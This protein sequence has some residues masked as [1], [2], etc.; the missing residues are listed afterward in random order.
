M[1]Y[2]IEHITKLYKEKDGKEKYALKDVSFC[3]PNNGLVVIK[4]KSG[5]GKSTLL[6]MLSLIDNPTKGDIYFNNENITKY[7]KRKRNDYRKRHISIIFQHYHLLDNETSLFNVMLPSLINGCS[8]KDAKNKALILLKDI[9]F[10]EKLYN[11][12]VKYLSG[13]EKERIAI[14]RSLINNPEVILADEPTGALDSQN[15][16]IT[17]DLLKK[18]SKKKLVIV[19]T[20]ND[21]LAS[22]YADRIITLKDGTIK[23]DKMVHKI[24]EIDLKINNAKRKHNDYYINH[25]TKS[26]FKK[27]FKRNLIS[28]I[29]LVIGLSSSLLIIGFSSG[30]TPSLKQEITKQFDYGVGSI[31]KEISHKIEGSPL[32]MVEMTRPSKE[33][34]E[35][36]E[37]N[38][39]DF[40][41]TYDYSSLVPMS[42]ETKHDEEEIEEIFYYPIYSY[43]DNY[44]DSSLLIDGYIPTTDSLKEVVIN[45]TCY[46]LLN[47]KYKFSPLNTYLHLYYSKEVNYFTGD[48]ERPY[49]SDYFVYEKEVKI[50]GVVDEMNF[51]SSPKIYYPY[52]SLI[53][54]L[55][56]TIMNNLSSYKEDFI[57]WYDYIASISNNDQLSSYQIK[58]FI[59][60]YHNY[61]KIEEISNNLSSPFSYSSNA[62]TIGGALLDLVKAATIGMDAFLVIAL[63]GT[64]LIL[65]IVSFSSYSED[66]KISAILS[67]LG[68]SEDDITSI[69]IYENVF[70]GL[71][72]LVI[73]LLISILLTPLVNKVIYL[74]S[75][76]SSLIN[77]P[78]DS[79]LSH[80][81]FLPILLTIS[82]F[83]VSILSTY[84]PI[85]FSKKV[86]IK[87]E[88]MS[89]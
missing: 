19:I 23:E 1:L 62:L 9:G 3:L 28:I 24:K 87:E 37:N 64:I 14:L 60:D 73:S 43:L 65:G 5:S 52:V 77:I 27:R 8:Y 81:F 82:T 29:S 18:E 47:K 21:E 17:M 56:N 46:N 71:I 40:T 86:S 2:R 7:R 20:H 10:S 48:N 34:I 85:S 59:N 45:K 38:Y 32:S 41:F 30:A 66:K 36:I 12:K 15:S 39:P 22:L 79:F 35:H 53:D 88:L 72:A 44:V 57:T 26:N 13:G 83:A 69:Y 76:F 6:N 78:F 58:A 84:L 33:E 51:L 31:S 75:G 63:L 25:L 49:I 55:Q 67:S 54:L 42:L 89:E 4:G 74:F 11:Q 61:A 68:S 70:I 80:R 50:V 16:L